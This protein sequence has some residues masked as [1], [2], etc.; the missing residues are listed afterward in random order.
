MK[1]ILKENE[2]T[3]IIINL[4]DMSLDYD[5]I[6]FNELRDV[7]TLTG[8][9]VEPIEYQESTQMLVNGLEAE[10]IKQVLKDELDI[11]DAEKYLV[12]N[13]DLEDNNDFPAYDEVE[14]CGDTA[15]NEIVDDEDV[16][17]ESLEEAELN[18]LEDTVKI[19]CKAALL[20]A[21]QQGI[22][23]IGNDIEDDLDDILNL[24]FNTS[25]MTDDE[26]EELCNVLLDEW[27]IMCSD[28]NSLYNEEDYEDNTPRFEKIKKHH[29]VLEKKKGC[30][31]KSKLNEKLNAFNN[32][33]QAKLDQI[34]ADVKKVLDDINNTTIGVDEARK[35]FKKLKS[36][37]A[38]LAK[39][40]KNETENYSLADIKGTKKVLNTLANVD[41]EK[42]KEIKN[43]Q[44]SLETKVQECLKANKNTLHENVSINNKSFAKYSVLELKAIYDKQIVSKKVLV[45]KLKS[46]N[47]SVVDKSLK[48]KL[49]IKNQL[50]ELINEELTYRIV[51][52]RCLKG[53]N[54]EMESEISD[55]ELNN[56][57]GASDDTKQEKDNTTKETSSK[58]TSTKENTEEIEEVELSR[59]EIT[60]KD[61]EA[62][63]EL[64]NACIEAG[65]PEDALEVEGLEETEESEEK[66]EES[67]ENKEKNEAYDYKNIRSLLFED[68]EEETEEKSEE[69]EETE[70]SE[71]KTEETA[72]KVILTDTD[73]TEELQTVL[74]TRYGIS[75][76]E[77]EEK[78]GG[79]IVHENDEEKSED[80]EKATEDNN[81]EETANKE[82]NEKSEDKELD[83]SELFKGL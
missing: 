31:P 12:S 15:I 6:D 59:I 45:E 65:I 81:T 46:L 28:E 71:E 66:T 70:E 32:K 55:E 78:I 67:E 73:Y 33:Q 27:D 39:I 16:D 24:S 41:I 4:A 36:E 22:I 72:I 11:D 48:E 53:L 5:N 35:A 10:D 68:A 74:N 63:E 50:L 57:F 69:S 23:K 52:E 62:A 26:Y 17:N 1:R 37:N 83:P 43:F 7:L 14:E 77:F 8:A 75:N 76:E 19:T 3:S 61:K 49:N 18:E 29:N 25:D 60:V 56:L 9:K 58:E 42:A 82:D 44:A 79:E 80:D 2:C 54:E 47:E 30:C 34:E 40:A 64:K 20:K 13:C 38:K 21:I 51:R